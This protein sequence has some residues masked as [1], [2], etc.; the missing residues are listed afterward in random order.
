MFL[1]IQNGR[2]IDHFK[3]GSSTKQMQRVFVLDNNKQP[4]MPAHP[5]RARALLSKGKAAVYRRA[6]FTIILKHRTGG[7]TQPIEIKVDPGSK[8]TG[9]ALVAE[10]SKGRRVIFAANCHHRGS[11]I[12]KKLDARRAHR[13]GRRT[14]TT[15]YRKP[16]FLHRTRPKGW[17]AP[18]LMSRVYN[19]QGWVNK[20]A[21]YAPAQAIA[22]ETVRFDMQKMQTPAITGIE[23]QQGTLQGYEVR[24]YLLEKFNRTCVYCGA[25]DIPLEIEH[26]NPKSKGGTNRISNLVIACHDCNQEKDT[27]PVETFLKDNPAKLKQI[28]AQL[29]SPLKDAAAVNATRYKIGDVLKHTGRPTTFWSGGRTK[30]NRIRQ[31]YPKDHWIDAACVG[32]T[33]EKVFI[34]ESHK[35]LI[36]HAKGHGSRQMCK[37]NRYGFPRTKAKSVKRIHGFQTGDWVRLNQPRGK[38]QGTYVGRVAVRERGDFDIMTTKNGKSVKIT[39]NYKNVTLL[40]RDDGYSYVA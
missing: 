5:A 18:S 12:K 11:L 1:L 17:L 30:M 28:L 2:V 8:V 23:Y 4:L 40:Q 9:L 7:D 20:L 32:K 37:M 10:F 34:C 36:I 16:R 14:R 15:R 6:P 33:G 13:R 21:R 39:S 19:I 27:R 25:Q 26:V 38:Y 24:E 3:Q 35:P 29:T 22:V 31:G